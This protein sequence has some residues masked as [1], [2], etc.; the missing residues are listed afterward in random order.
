MLKFLRNAEPWTDYRVW[1]LLGVVLAVQSADFSVG[2]FYAAWM[3]IFYGV[4]AVGCYTASLLTFF[5][6]YRTHKIEV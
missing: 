1:L 5:V 2:G 4:I 6:D 3:T